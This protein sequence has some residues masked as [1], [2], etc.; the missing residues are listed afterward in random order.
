MQR[1]FDLPHAQ[2]RRM[3]RCLH[4][5]AIPEPSSELLSASDEAIAALREIQG[6]E[7]QPPE[8]VHVT[9]QRLDAY[10]EDLR[11]PAWRKLLAAAPSVLSHRRTFEL[12]FEKPRAMSH[13]VEA[14]AEGGV[15]WARLIADIR[16]MVLAHLPDGVLV[17]PPLVPHYSLAYCTEDRSDE[18]VESALKPTATRT[19]MRVAEVSLV[20]VTQAPRE[21]RFSFDVLER[22]PLGDRLP[23]S[24]LAQ[25]QEHVR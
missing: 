17:P 11:A 13:A 21:G 23:P 5:Y 19:R 8:F 7:V 10:E 14:V 9:L 4:L 1:F 12:A 2:W 25:E 6:I 3:D 24:R 15:H 20:S 22:W 18:P 16:Q